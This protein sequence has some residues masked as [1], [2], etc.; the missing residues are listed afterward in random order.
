M[1]NKYSLKQ[2]IDFAFGNY[3]KWEPEMTLFPEEFQ[4]LTGVRCGR[5]KKGFLRRSAIT[6]L[7]SWVIN[8]CDN[9]GI[10]MT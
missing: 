10:V 2:R 7:S 4:H 9:C 5:C 8:R 3:T 6:P 1:S